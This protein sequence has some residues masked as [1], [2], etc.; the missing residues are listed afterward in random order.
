MVPPSISVK[1]EVDLNKMLIGI[2]SV[3]IGSKALQILQSAA[4]WPHA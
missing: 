2:F 3:F 1:R 4:K